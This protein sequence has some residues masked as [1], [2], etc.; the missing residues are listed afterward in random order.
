MKRHF[1]GAFRKQES[2]PPM[3]RVPD[4]MLYEQMI[5]ELATHY[6]QCKYHIAHN[7]TEID[8]WEMICFENNKSGLIKSRHEN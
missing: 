5:H 4:E 7:Y 1:I 2:I 3:F 6:G 8:F